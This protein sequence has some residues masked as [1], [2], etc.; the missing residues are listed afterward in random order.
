MNTYNSTPRH[1]HYLLITLWTILITK[2]FTFEYLTMAYE[3][4]INSRIYIWSLSLFMATFASIVYL[5]LNQQ[6]ARTSMLRSKV[7][8]IWLGAILAIL[9]CGSIGLTVEWIQPMYLPSFF[10]AIIATAYTAQF[11]YNREGQTVA[12]LLGWWLGAA[13]LTA[14]PAPLPVIGFAFCML[15]FTTLPSFISYLQ[16]NRR[17][18]GTT[19][20]ALSV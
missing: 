12:S 5:R 4:P 13:T 16:H 15:S 6:E 9:V 17:Q 20:K 7:V 11:L 18:S 8:I 14:L 2:C 1:K 19:I 10:A 3:V